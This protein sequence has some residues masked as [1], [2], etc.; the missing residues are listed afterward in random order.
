MAQRSPTTLRAAVVLS[1]WVGSPTAGF[2]C[3]FGIGALQMN[4]EYKVRRRP[5]VSPRTSGAIE[6]RL[7]AMESEL[8]EKL[9]RHEESPKRGLKRLERLWL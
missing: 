6:Q 7:V 9:I 3:A 8:E 1:L 5:F 4:R 2:Y